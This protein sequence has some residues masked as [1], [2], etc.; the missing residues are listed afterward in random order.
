MGLPF[1][2]IHAAAPRL[3]VPAEDVGLLPD[4]IAA[5]M[6]DASLRAFHR[7]VELALAE[8]VDLVLIT[9]EIGAGPENGPRAATRLRDGLQRLIDQGMRVVLA[10]EADD[11]F[12]RLSVEGWPDSVIM[13]TPDRPAIDITSA[14]G[15]QIMVAWC[16][17]DP[18]QQVEPGPLRIGL[19]PGAFEGVPA[20]GYDYLAWTDRRDYFV[21]DDLP[22]ELSPGTLQ[23]R[24]FNSDEVGAKGA[25][26]VSVDERGAVEHDFVPLDVL[27]FVSIE[28]GLDES[29]SPPAVARSLAA[30]LDA[31]RSLHAGSPLAVEA[32]LDL[33][34]RQA[35]P[36][37]WP[38]IRDET[39]R[40]LRETA[41]GLAPFVWWSQL[42]LR[43]RQTPVW[44]GAGRT[45]D[46]AAGVLELAAGLA[47]DPGRRAALA[48]DRSHGGELDG[49]DLG[50]AVGRLV[51]RSRH[52]A[53]GSV[54][55]LE[56]AAEL[57]IDALAGGSRGTQ[58]NQSD[59]S[60]QSDQGK[61]SR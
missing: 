21:S 42:R 7:L 9:G 20:D 15:S 51:E 8:R 41:E 55:L 30:R 57:A 28:L 59:Q 1:R 16:S 38:S 23:G 56:E 54:E 27:R 47:G 48:A 44:E 24:S 10:T 12:S 33:R 25:V 49:L 13:L 18:E 2:F 37:G 32:T 45:D 58:D 61:W 6:R 22:L 46:F 11:W 39:L 43:H 36:A 34:G 17:D 50:D 52:E 40:L 26:L 14:S 3:D 19:L 31:L 60:N 29:V 4:S 53:A 5:N 35:I